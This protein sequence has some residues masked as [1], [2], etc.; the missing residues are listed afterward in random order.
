MQL[1]SKKT[2]DVGSALDGAKGITSVTLTR[3]DMNHLLSMPAEE[4]KQYFVHLYT[5][6]DLSTR[7]R[8]PG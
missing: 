1:N 6:F 4:L 7:T 2:V 8:S 5:K 3:R